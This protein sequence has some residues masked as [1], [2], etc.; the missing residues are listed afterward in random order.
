MGGRSAERDEALV[1]LLKAKQESSVS[2]VIPTLDHE[3]TI[4]ALVGVVAEAFVRRCRLVDEVLVVDGGSRDRTCDEAARA[5][6]TVLLAD[7]VRSDVGP[8]LG[9]GD[10]LWRSIGA[11]SGDVIVWLDADLTTFRADYI[12]AL[13]SP[14]LLEQ[15]VQLVRGTSGDGGRP[16]GDGGLVTEAVARPVL[17]TLAPEFSRLREPMGGEYAGRR[18]ALRSVP[19]EPDHGAEIGLVLDIAARYGA[20]AVREVD[21]GGR[22]HGSRPLTHRAQHTRSVLRAILT[23]AGAA[24]PRGVL[25]LRPALDESMPTAVPATR[26]GG[27]R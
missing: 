10:L 1:E 4:G 21:L 6:A 7:D 15:R 2:V 11:A 23:R 3:T 14:L 25:P 19:F 17:A 12:I 9:H 22:E 20:D 5:G 18:T 13:L 8:V 24:S 27:R 16:L 26:S